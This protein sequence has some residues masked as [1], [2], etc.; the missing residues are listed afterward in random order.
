M[1]L[2]NFEVSRTE[3][4]I[5]NSLPQ[6]YPD[7][8]GCAF[9]FDLAKPLDGKNIELA[10][11]PEFIL[12]D[13]KVANVKHVFSAR[14]V[15]TIHSKHTQEENYHIFYECIRVAIEDVF[16]PA[17]NDLGLIDYSNPDIFHP[18]A[19]ADVLQDLRE[20][21]EANAARDKRSFS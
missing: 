12:F 10:I 3:P 17:F 15:F 7:G 19:F 2:E 11:T 5:I 14:S 6:I 1:S 4:V 16:Q 21:F 13:K 8:L 20:L 9:R 18:P